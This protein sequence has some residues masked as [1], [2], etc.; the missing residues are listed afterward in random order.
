MRLLNAMLIATVSLIG[1]S[2]PASAEPRV[3][4][5]IKPIHSLVAAVMQGVGEPSLIVDGGASPHTYAM[6]PSNAAD[7]E[8]ADIV[9]WAGDDLEAFLVKPIETLGAKAKSVELVDAPGLLHLPLRE[10]GSF[11]A[12]EHGAEEAAGSHE[13]EAAAGHDHA[14]HDHEAATE[15]EGH[16]AHAGH[17]HD[18]IDMHFWLDPVNAKA[19]VAVIAATLSE[20]DPADAAA[21]AANAAKVSAR[22][23]SL[24]ASTKAALAP[25]AGKPFIVFHDAYQYFENRFGVT[26]AGSITVSPESIPGVQRIA[27]IQEKV[28]SLGATCVFAEPQFEPKLVTVVTEGSEARTGVLDPEGAALEDGPELYFQLIDGLTTALTDCLTPQG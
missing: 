7:L 25:V 19:M 12:H 27:E 24:T 11:D 20:A 16:A 21:Y 2:V 1:L 18:E 28:R 4:A 6:K 15:H 26:A 17:G 10:G 22:L 13:A 5:S 9:F 14:G 8:A 3:V 23:D